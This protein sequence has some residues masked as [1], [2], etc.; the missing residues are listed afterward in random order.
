MDLSSVENRINRLHYRW[1][2]GSTRFRDLQPPESKENGISEK[3]KSLMVPL[4]NLPKM[5]PESI[6]PNWHLMDLIIVEE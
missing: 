1:R 4:W 2:I 6:H 5:D 3:P